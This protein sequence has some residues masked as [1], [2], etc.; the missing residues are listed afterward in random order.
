MSSCTG[1]W[2]TRTIKSAPAARRSLA[3]FSAMG[4]EGANRNVP[5]LERMAE[6]SS[7]RPMT[8]IFT[9]S[10]SKTFVS[11]VPG[12]GCPSASLRFAASTGTR[13]LGEPLTEH[14]L[15]EVELVISGHEDVDARHVRQ[16]D[17][18][19]ALVEAG[20]ERGREGIARMRDDG[21]RIAG[22]LGL[23]RGRY[24]RK[25]AAPALFPDFIDVAEEGERHSNSAVGGAGGR[26]KDR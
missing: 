14:R 15:A 12:S 16:L 13:K 19:L 18:G 23:D 7:V 4:I 5:G 11:P 10:N 8:P 6:L 2:M 1:A 9:P 25:T 3:L 20:A 17:D 21:V 22:P 24:A 26:D